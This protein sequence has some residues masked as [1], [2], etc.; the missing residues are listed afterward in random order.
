MTLAHLLRRFRDYDLDITYRK[1]G[2]REDGRG[3]WFISVHDFSADIPRVADVEGPSF[4][5]ALL[6]ATKVIR[7]GGE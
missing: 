5:A 7:E 2:W 1:R 6:A 3:R 4:F